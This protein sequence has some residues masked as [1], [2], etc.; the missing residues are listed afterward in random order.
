M[1]GSSAG[2]RRWLPEH[3]QFAVDAASVALWCWD[4]DTDRLSMDAFGFE[5]WGLPWKDEVSF[6]ELS[7]HI[8]PADRDRV[9]A[10]FQATRSVSGLYETDF[11]IM[12][13]DE[14]RWVSARG[15]GADEGLQD[16]SSFGVFI[17]VTQRKQA[18]EANELL[19][20]EMSHR[21]LNLL[22][23]ATSLTNMTG[24]KAAS[25][26]DMTKELVQRLTALGR[27]HS[28]V[29][30][31]PGTEG[32][33]ALLGDLIAVLLSPYDDG[34]AFA[35]RIRTSVPR[36]G[37][38]ETSATTLAMVIHELATNSLKHGALSVPSGML[39]ITSTSDDDDLV[40]VW[41][42]TGGPAVASVPDRQGYG[43]RVVLKTVEQQLR[44]ELAFD[45]QAAGLVAKLRV[46]RSRLAL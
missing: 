45:W 9:R 28:L 42:E 23:I 5:L 17:D 20:G 21:V 41:A 11:R 8:H 7:A 32:R 4:V 25:V 2:S 19:A 22:T 36:M 43:S 24:R 34:G 10:A 16:R 46:K 40:I 15:K 3:L 6:D 33:A 27:A 35:G 44:G 31:L 39:E 26:P 29:R 14:I 13:G 12:L 1:S 30:P 38:G 37:V 18:E